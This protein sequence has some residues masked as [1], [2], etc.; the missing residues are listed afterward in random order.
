MDKYNVSVNLK[1]KIYGDEKVYVASIREYPDCVGQGDTVE[2]AYDEVMDN[3]SALIENSKENGEELKILNFEEKYSGKILLRLPKSL[4]RQLAMQAE[5]EG[6][7]LNTCIINSLAQKTS[8][9]DVINTFERL[10][11]NVSISIQ[12]EDL[13]YRLPNFKSYITKKLEVVYN[14]TGI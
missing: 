11:S 7:S 2:E 3:F 1:L 6:V 4:H 9:F 5:N 13:S 10:I 8:H 14:G 12:N